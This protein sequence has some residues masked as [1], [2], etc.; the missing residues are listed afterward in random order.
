MYISID[1]L[2]KYGL[3]ALTVLHILFDLLILFK[4]KASKSGG[5]SGVTLG[6]IFQNLKKTAVSFINYIE[7]KF[8]NII[9]L[10]KAITG[11]EKTDE[12]DHA[13]DK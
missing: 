9:G 8:P 3:I 11:G 7:P 6:E 12:A 5:A 13:E 10:I 1:I 4:I 2:I